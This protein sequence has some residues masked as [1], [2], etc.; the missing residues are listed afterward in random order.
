MAIAQTRV[1]GPRP[2]TIRLRAVRPQRHQEPRQSITH[3]S[4]ECPISRRR[5]L[6]TAAALAVPSIIPARVL[7]AESPS[8]RINVGFIGT[9]D[10]GTT[11]N[12]RRYLNF[13]DAR[14]RVVCDVDGERMRRAKEIVDEQYLNQDCAMTKDFR[15]V[16]AREDIDAVMISTP[17]I[18]TPS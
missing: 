2:G 4:H 1:P 3:D 12:L 11:W 8:H 9:G 6:H 17:T 5:F 16:L 14:V 7:G 15:E 13:K 18:G 10:H